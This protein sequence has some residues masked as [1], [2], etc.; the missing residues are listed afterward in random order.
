MRSSILVTMATLVVAAPLSQRAVAADEGGVEPAAG[1]P[2]EPPALSAEDKAALTELATALPRHGLM[3]LA[4]PDADA[5]DEAW[6]RLARRLVGIFAPA[7]MK[8]SAKKA[9]LEARPLAPELLALVP[10]HRRYRALMAMLIEQARRMSEPQVMVPATRYRLKAGVTAPEIGLLRDRLR[11][12]GYG[13]EGVQGRLRDYFD[14][15]L[16]RALQAWQKDRG[17]PPTIVLDPLTR[18]RLNEPIAAPVAEIALALE[19]FRELE[20]RADRGR[21]LIVHLNDYRLVAERDG[22]PELAMPVIVGKASERDQTPALSTTLLTVIAN[23][24]WGVPQRLVDEKLRPEAHDV[25]ELLIDKGY[26]VSVDDSGR[27]RVRMRPGPD[28][29]LGRLKFVLDDTDGVYLHDTNARSAFGKDDR[30]LSLGC[31]RVSDPVGLAR[32]VL[33]GRELD[34]DEALA[35][36]TLSTSFDGGGLP[37]H[38][39][40]QTMLVEDG[41]LVR[42]PDIYG[43]DPEALARID[44]PALA[45]A[46]RASVEPEGAL[47][48]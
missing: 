43:R 23:P 37:T 19:R 47:A 39:V 16:K 40:Y 29:P 42:F 25:P 10:T 48:P 6:L 33:P 28:N 30:T 21:Q 27:W 41:R 13:D 22:M 20:L 32:W 4:T 24:T 36:A 34:L 9:L 35:Y 38:L 15:R 46:L 5:A 12:E 26:E 45:A 7:R 14:D 1:A 3:P 2:E 18:R 17:L 44:A 31:V 11:A 8:G